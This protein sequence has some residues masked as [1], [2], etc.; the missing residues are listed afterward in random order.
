GIMGTDVDVILHEE[1]EHDHE[2]EG[3]HH[4][5]EHEGHHHKHE[6]GHSHEGHE[7][8]HDHRNFKA[9]KVMIDN[10]TLDKKVK[11]LSKEIFYN[12][13]KAEA[14]IHGK[15]ID[16]VHFHEVGAVDSIVDIVG[17]AICFCKLDV[18]KVVAS[19]LHTGIGTIKC[20]H[21]IIP[22][23][24]PATLE[25]LREGKVPFYSKGIEKE[26]VT[27][28]GAAIVATL[29]EEFHP[30]E[31]GTVVAVGY[32]C[33]KRDMKIANMLRMMLVETKKKLF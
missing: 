11:E 17:T 23:P 6:H 2:H 29:A 13:A 9:I 22:I 24:A 26:M 28:T 33:G 19:P 10:S 18:D 12:V 21:G 14:K 16:E 27:P 5:H 8:S 3:H 31:E 15:E 20:Q 7:H 32:G 30:L 25:I 1:E 4:E